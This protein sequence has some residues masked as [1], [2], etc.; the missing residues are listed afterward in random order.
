MDAPEKHETWSPSLS[1]SSLAGFESRAARFMR[2]TSSLFGLMEVIVVTSKVLWIV[3]TAAVPLRLL[4][5]IL[6]SFCSTSGI[7]WTSLFHLVVPLVTLLLHTSR[8]R[9]LGLIFSMEA[10]DSG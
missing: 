4:S 3:E 5:S 1:I 8:S 6:P 2:K 9:C 10:V 7:G